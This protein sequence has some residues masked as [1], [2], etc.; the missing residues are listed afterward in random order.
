MTVKTSVKKGTS[1][2]LQF[3]EEDAFSA[4]KKAQ[5][6]LM[7]AIFALEREELAFKKDKRLLCSNV[8]F[9]QEQ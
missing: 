3:I 1:Q 4:G 6:Q 5:P 9:L 8:E 2:N 7:P